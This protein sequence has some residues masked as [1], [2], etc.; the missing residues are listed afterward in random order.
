MSC[1][2]Y[3]ELTYAYRVLVVKPEGRGPP[4]RQRCRW[5]ENIK[6]VLKETGWEGVYWIDLI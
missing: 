6:V 1:G 4:V 2:K 3:R 5:E